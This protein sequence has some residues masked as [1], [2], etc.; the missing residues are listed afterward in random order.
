MADWFS[1]RE[2]RLFNEK[3]YSLQQ[4]VLRHLDTHMQKNEAESILYSMYKK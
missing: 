3:E 4:M 1:I 2:P